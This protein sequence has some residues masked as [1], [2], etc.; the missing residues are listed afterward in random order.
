MQRQ[1]S[2]VLHRPQWVELGAARD[3]SMTVVVQKPDVNLL[4]KAAWVLWHFVWPVYSSQ[5]SFRESSNSFWPTF[6]DADS[7]SHV[8]GSLTEGKRVSQQNQ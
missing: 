5:L 7:S 6:P 8:F 1:L 2:V 4:G 3:R